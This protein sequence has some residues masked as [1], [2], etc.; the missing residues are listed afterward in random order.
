MRS[1]FLFSTGR[2]YCYTNRYLAFEGYAGLIE[3]FLD[4]IDFTLPGLKD[5]LSHLSILLPGI[6]I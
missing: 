5:Q 1:K 6:A 3:I 2:A 4:Y